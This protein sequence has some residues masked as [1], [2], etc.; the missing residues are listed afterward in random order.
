MTTITVAKND[1]KSIIIMNCEGDGA[2]SFSL[3]DNSP[4]DNSYND[5]SYK[6]NSKR[7]RHSIDWISSD[8]ITK[9]LRDKMSSYFNEKGELSL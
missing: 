9:S 5:N 7:N 2:A 4:G 8:T 1:N 3:N 6:D